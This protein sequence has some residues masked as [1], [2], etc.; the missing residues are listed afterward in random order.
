MRQSRRW[1]ASTG[2]VAIGL[3]VIAVFAPG[4]LA[5]GAPSIALT[6]SAHDYGTIDPNTTASQTFV[7][8]NTGG[9]ATGALTVKLTGSSSFARTSDSCTGTALGPKKQCSV[10]VRYAPTTAGSSDSGTLTVSAKKPSAGASAALIGKAS[11]P[12]SQSQI[13][14][15]SYGG[16]FAPGSGGFP[17]WTCDGWNGTAGGDAGNKEQ[18]L[19]ADCSSDGGPGFTTNRDTSAEDGPYDSMC[20]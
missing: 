16:T 15:E 5:G 10:T 2:F 18:Q 11:Q 4:V 8:K 6:P 3:C 13:D 7:L 19:I 1:W 20:L 9:S 12:K 17:L 14:C